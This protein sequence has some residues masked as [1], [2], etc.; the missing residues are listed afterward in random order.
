MNIIVCIKQVPGTPEVKINPSDNTLVR[1]DIPNIINPFDTY[2]IEEGLRLKES[3]GGRV[4]VIS[5]GPPQAVSALR[6][7]IGMGA[8]DGILLSDRVF[9]GSDTWA[10]A[11][12]LSLAIKKIETFDI[13]LC[14]KQAIDGDTGQVGP[15]IARQLGISQLTYVF[16]IRNV[17]LT[18]GTITVDRLLEEGHEIAE[19]RM[20]A[21]LTVVKDI[22]QPRLSSLA[23]I[24][25]I[26][27]IRTQTAGDLTGADS[28]KMGLNGSPTKV[29]KIFT[30]P[31]RE[32]A[33]QL[34]EADD[35][36]RAAEKLADL[37]MSR[38][39]L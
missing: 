34:I 31:K 37:I 4:T 10:T 7:A 21:V 32:G 33:L 26:R 24:R 5:M 17:D 19:A 12:T 3:F 13:I 8:D 9:A 6:E 38:K 2:A 1:T 18:A 30:P 36:D 14:G 27:N 15:G 25:R 35:A 16:K 22:N 20:P 28:S 11:Y 23:N 29:I 39:I